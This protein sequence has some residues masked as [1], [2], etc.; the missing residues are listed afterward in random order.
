MDDRIAK[1]IGDIFMKYVNE[2]ANSDEAR[3]E[4]YKVASKRHEKLVSDIR[5]KNIKRI[6]QRGG[7]FSEHEI[8]FFA[9]AAGP[10]KAGHSLADQDE[11]D[12]DIADA[13]AEHL[14]NYLYT[15]KE[16][17]R[18]LD[19]SINPSQEQIGIMAQDLQEVNPACI[20]KAPDGTLT[21]DTGKLALMNA[22]VIADLARRLN[23]L[24]NR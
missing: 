11:W 3:S 22:G 16:S 1:V 24:E 7:P 10:D 6:L 14:Q 4:A 21:V 19:P 8:A 5:C 20:V 23:A 13:Y 9:E 2:W 15:Y 18:D 12:S 17:A